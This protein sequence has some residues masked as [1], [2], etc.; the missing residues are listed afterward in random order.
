[1]ILADDEAILLDEKNREVDYG[2]FLAEIWS[3]FFAAGDRRNAPGWSVNQE[4]LTDVIGWGIE[5]TDTCCLIPYLALR[6]FIQREAR[7]WLAERHL[8]VADNG[9]Y[10]TINIPV[11]WQE[12]A[13]EVAGITV[14]SWYSSY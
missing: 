1:M 8:V 10:K 12:L 4:H 6:R 11:P 13:G 2:D 14:H 5:K 3:V 9:R 7:H